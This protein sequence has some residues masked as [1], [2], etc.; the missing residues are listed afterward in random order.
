MQLD[1]PVLEHLWDSVREGSREKKDYKQ[2]LAGNISESFCIKDRD[3]LFFKNACLP[4]VKQHLNVMKKPPTRFNTIYKSRPQ[5]VLG[6]FWANFQYKHEFNPVHS[7]DGVYSFVVWM[8][9]PYSTEELRN[10]PQFKGTPKEHV[11]PGCFVFQFVNGI[12]QIQNLPIELSPEREGHMVLFPSTL[13]HCVYPSM[14][15]MN[16]GFHCPA[17]YFSKT[18]FDYMLIFLRILF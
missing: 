7:H 12:G 17:T 8:K 1:K 5:L 4:A 6:Q 16:P 3:N 10:A 15:Q 13:S 11:L 18:C 14:A 2:S 9:I